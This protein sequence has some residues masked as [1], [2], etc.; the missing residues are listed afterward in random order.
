MRASYGLCCWR[1]YDGYRTPLPT[2]LVGGIAV[3]VAFLVG[4][5]TFDSSPSPYLPLFLGA[6]LLVTVGFIDDLRGTSVRMRFPA[7][8]LACLLLSSWGGILLNDLGHIGSAG[9]LVSLG[10]FAVCRASHSTRLSMVRNCCCGG[11]STALSSA[12]RRQKG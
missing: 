9:E 6:L 10:G 7:Q 8:I 1:T 11:H 12:T 3:F 4:V 2:P 5:L